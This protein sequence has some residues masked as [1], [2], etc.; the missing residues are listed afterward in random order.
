MATKPTE[1]TRFIDLLKKADGWT[2]ANRYPLEVKDGKGEVIG[3]LYF[4]PLTKAI[5]KKVASILAP[6][7]GE[8]VNFSDFQSDFN[9]HVLIQLAENEDGSKAFSIG[10]FA[11]LTM[12]AN[13]NLLSQI[14]EFMFNVGIK[15][16]EEEKKPSE[17]T[18]IVDSPS[19]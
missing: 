15:S 8:E 7:K 1:Q 11:F 17:P 2:S 3:T 12:E 19:S 6:K 5:R 10:D 9:T 13:A 4:R 14:E 18:P 16:V